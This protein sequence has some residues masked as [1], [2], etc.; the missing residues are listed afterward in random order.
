MAKNTFSDFLKTATLPTS[1]K[2]VDLV[3]AILFVVVVLMIVIPLPAFLLDILLAINIALSVVILLTSI[4]TADPLEFSVFPSILLMTTVFGLA[5]NI[6]STRLILIQG[7]AFNVQIIRGFG[8]FVVGGNYIVGFVIFIIIMAVQFI[9]IT[10]GATRISEVAARFKLDEFPNKNMALESDFSSGNITHEERSRRQTK[11]QQESEFYSSMDGASKFVQGNVI[12]SLIITV[13]NFVGGLIIGMVT[14]G[15]GFQDAIRNYALFTIGDGLVSQVPALLISTATGII[16]TRSSLSTS[17][18]GDIIKQLSAQPKAIMVAAGV[19]ALLF[20][21]PGFPKIPLFFL[22]AILGSL[23]YVQMANSK[24]K[25]EKEEKVAA[26][27]KIQDKARSVKA[28][29]LLHV[30]PLALEIGYSLIPLAD[31]DNGGDLLDR[32]AGI[33]RNIA[34]DLG[35]VIPAVRIR[36]NV[37]FEPSTYVVLIKGVEMGRG[38]IRMN[39][40]LAIPFGEIIEPIKG[41]T[42]LEPAYGVEAVWI[43]ESQRQKAEL[44]GYTIV[45]SGSIIATHL[46]EIVRQYGYMLLGRDEVQKQ[47]DQLK[48]TNPVL[49]D[50]CLKAVNL[51]AVQK[52]LQNLLMEKVSIRDMVTILETLSDYGTSVRNT[53][54]LT[55]YVRQALKRQITSVYK[56]QENSLKV[57]T[58]DPEIEELL[59]NAV[60]EEA[61]GL[62]LTLD[63][64]VM[65][66]IIHRTDAVVQRVR[67]QGVGT[68]ILL[69]PT[70]IR[71]VLR[72]MIQAAMPGVVVLAF[73]EILS[74]V[75]IRAM[76]VVSFRQAQN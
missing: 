21:I 26:D 28:D 5:L 75:Q 40:Y 36:D 23:G 46:T 61:G 59:L 30:D 14:R 27:K 19:L 71:G 65:K 13:V 17:F 11:L 69:V 66:G 22:A 10:R 20:F 54:M 56:D 45:D 52:V 33:R 39:H 2:G 16:I 25:K 67:K 48:K 3:V 31:Q 51:G 64:K 55:E 29:D 43:T 42:T 34:L 72:N 35:L 57:I 9:V 41:E 73:G 50:E 76:D 74:T 62:E 37:R 47:L 15:E 60:R 24:V 70:Q 18:A 6:S 7:A 8:D 12:V 58:L 32:I 53:D 38:K 63:P 49:V 68:P 1:G 4:Y 44:S